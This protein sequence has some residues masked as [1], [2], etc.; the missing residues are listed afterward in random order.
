MNYAIKTLEHR[1]GQINERIK[2]AQLIVDEPE[3]LCDYEFAMND[4]GNY[5][6]EIIELESAIKILIAE[7]P[8]PKGNLP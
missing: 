1:I 8:A 7:Q 6:S 2:E 3:M 5:Q 4:I